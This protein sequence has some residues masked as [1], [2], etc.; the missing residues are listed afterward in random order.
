M[1]HDC[2]MVK[3]SDSILVLRTEEYEN[4][5]FI[6]NLCVEQ[7]GIE[8]SPNFGNLIQ[9]CHFTLGNSY[10]LLRG[11]VEKKVCLYKYIPFCGGI[12]L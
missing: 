8:V 11:I 6:P 3:E 10:L 12:L 5:D 9:V 2:K 7:N 1:A 4:A